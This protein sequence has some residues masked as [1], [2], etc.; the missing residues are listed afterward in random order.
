MIATKMDVSGPEAMSLKTEDR[1]SSELLVAFPPTDDK[2]Q[3]DITAEFLAP[4]VFAATP[5]AAEPVARPPARKRKR[6]S[7]A[8]GPD[9]DEK[10]RINRER[11]RQ[12]ASRCRQNKKA[13]NQHIADLAAAL[14]RDNGALRVRLRKER[15][16]LETLRR[17]LQAHASC[18]HPD[19]ATL[20]ASFGSETAA[21]ATQA[22]GANELFLPPTSA[23]APSGAMLSGVPVLG[24]GSFDPRVMPSNAQVAPTSNHHAHQ[25]ALAQPLPTDDLSLDFMH[26]PPT[27]GQPM[28]ITGQPPQQQ[29]MLSHPQPQQPLSGHSAD[30]VGAMG[31]AASPDMAPTDRGRTHARTDSL[32][33]NLTSTPSPFTMSSLGG[34]DSIPRRD[35]IDTTGEFS[36]FTSWRFCFSCPSHVP[37]TNRLRSDVTI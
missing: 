11:N 21:P 10:R 14:E 4:D 32:Q 19:I 30:L 18:G 24:D 15:E 23:P 27:A 31:F 26:M 36:L 29:P 20:L 2:P 35:S 28:Y 22:V 16:E 25:M 9:A 3:F 33:S 12:A 13:K 17:A 37:I 5:A 6:L 7:R 8:S 1:D 34:D